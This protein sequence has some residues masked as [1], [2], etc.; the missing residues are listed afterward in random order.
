MGY[1][2]LEI[3]LSS[4]DEEGQ[5]RVEL[6]FITEDDAERTPV[7]GVA[8]LDPLDLVELE[9]PRGTS[10]ASHLPSASSP[11]RPFAPGTG[12]SRPRSKAATSSCA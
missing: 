8:A 3:G 10:T 9:T 12:S 4:L 2:E 1:A 11:T 6:R 5:Y 7:R